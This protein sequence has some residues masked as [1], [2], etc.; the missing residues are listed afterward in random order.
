MLGW[1]I[2][3]TVWLVVC[4]TLTVVIV[5]HNRRVRREWQETADG[6]ATAYQRDQE[7]ERGALP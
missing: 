4:V 7:R 3:I 6:W 2:G 5:R 1:L